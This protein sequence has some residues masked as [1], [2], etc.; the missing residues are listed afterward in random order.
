MEFLIELEVR[1]I[2][3]ELKMNDYLLFFEFL[4]HVYLET[5]KQS[6][7]YSIASILDFRL[8]NKIIINSRLP[9]DFCLSRLEKIML[10]LKYVG[11][12]DL[13]KSLPI[14]I[15]FLSK[16]VIMKIVS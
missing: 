15:I 12:I 8:V 9:I 6:E 2:F 10:C 5:N 4:D 16:I 3:L 1:V 11:T 13:R 14:F 7:P